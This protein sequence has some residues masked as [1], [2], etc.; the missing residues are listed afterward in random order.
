MEDKHECGCGCG[1]GCG[2]SSGCGGTRVIKSGSVNKDVSGSCTSGNY[3]LAVS[4]HVSAS[5]SEIA[6]VDDEG[7]ILRTYL[8]G[9][10][11]VTVSGKRDVNKV[12]D[13]SYETSGFSTMVY[14]D[15]TLSRWSGSFPLSPSPTTT[16]SQSTSSSGTPRS[17]NITVNYGI[18]LH[19]NGSQVINGG[20]ASLDVYF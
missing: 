7:H 17:V 1:C 6:E 5:V 15:I 11:V 20:S 19:E 13:V 4:G 9:S 16:V 2:S 12:G 10:A 8:E 14:H 18:E 3:Y